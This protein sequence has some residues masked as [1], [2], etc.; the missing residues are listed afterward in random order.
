MLAEGVPSADADVGTIA[1]SPLETL[2]DARPRTRLPMTVRLPAGL[3]AGALAAAA[4][5]WLGPASTTAS[6]AAAAATVGSRYRPL[7]WPRRLPSRRCRAWGGCSSR[8]RS[9]PGWPA[10]GRRARP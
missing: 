4:V 6:T 8:S 9:S 7:G 10:A 1:A 5:A 3:A 2:A